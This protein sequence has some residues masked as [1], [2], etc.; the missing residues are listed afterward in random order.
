LGF[1]TIIRKRTLNKKMTSSS[2][3]FL[4]VFDKG[5]VKRRLIRGGTGGE[6]SHEAW[7]VQ[8]V[9]GGKNSHESGR[10]QSRERGAEEREKCCQRRNTS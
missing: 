4:H 2:S 8:Y 7:H 3:F 9:L 6:R 10:V 5:G 1:G